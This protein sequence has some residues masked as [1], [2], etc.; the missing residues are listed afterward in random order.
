MYKLNKKNYS[1]SK[2]IKSSS[3]WLKRKI[4]LILTAFMV[5]IS[6]GMY[7]EDE[8]TNDNQNKTEQKQ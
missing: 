6:N 7:H 5:G 3:H 2:I 4:I 8:M 1:I